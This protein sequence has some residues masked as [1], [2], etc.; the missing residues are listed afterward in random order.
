MPRL[1]PRGRRNL[2]RG[3]NFGVSL[4]RAI[5]AL[6]SLSSDSGIGVPST[7]LGAVDV[8]ERAAVA[9]AVLGQ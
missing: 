4:M 7:S 3:M 1:E 6:F 8:L 9:V 2:L 5:V